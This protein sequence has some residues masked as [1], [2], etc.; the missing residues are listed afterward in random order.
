MIKHNILVTWMM[1]CALL[2][3]PPPVLAE[4]SDPKSGDSGD[5]C[6][7]FRVV[8]VCIWIYYSYYEI[9]ISVTIKYGHFNPDVLINVINPQGVERAEDPKRTDTL[10]RNHQNLKF[11]T[12]TAI[13]H[14]LT[15]Q[16]YCPSIT[17]AGG[18][19]F[20]SS[21]DIPT[22]RWGGLDVFTLGAWIPGIHE[23]GA[24]PLNTWGGLYPRTGWTIQYSP[25]KAAAIIAQRVGD[26][27]TRDKEP[28]IYNSIAG[29]PILVED[30][31]WTWTPEGLKE[32]TNEEGWLQPTHP[33]AEMCQ[34]AGKYD[35]LNKTGWGGGR[36]SSNGEYTYGLWRPYTCCEIERGFLI[37]ISSPYPL[38]AIT[39]P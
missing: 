3:P 17:S 19:Y 21:I 27:I 24:W 12:A 9:E 15:G 16:I 29:D 1:F 23:I 4:Q 36:V 31:K 28:H 20:L 33:D 35:V 18:L 26:I 10:T 8:G 34:L 13:G 5:D 22:W 30:N 25:P 39:N 11:Q 14:P 6:V 32:N 37:D 2:M 38:P 7:Q